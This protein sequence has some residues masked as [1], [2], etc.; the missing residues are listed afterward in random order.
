MGHVW[1][2]SSGEDHSYQQ[3]LQEFKLAVNNCDMVEI[4][5]KKNGNYEY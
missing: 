2:M 4:H 3:T 5:A 1:V